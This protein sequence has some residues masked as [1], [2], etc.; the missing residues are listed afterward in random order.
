MALSRPTATPKTR[1]IR[2][3]WSS[4]GRPPRCDPGMVQGD[5]P[6]VVEGDE[7]LQ[8]T[9]L[10]GAVAEGPGEV[11]PL[12]IDGEAAQVVRDIYAWFVSGGMSKAA[13]ARRLNACGIPNPTAYKR[14]LC[15]TSGSRKVSIL[16]W[17]REMNRV[18]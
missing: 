15:T 14:R 13:I 5:E 16:G 2:T 4:T 11:L 18:L 7:L 9:P 17:Y 8:K 3:P 12:V 6:G 10:V 1:R